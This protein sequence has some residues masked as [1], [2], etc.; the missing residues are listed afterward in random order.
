[1]KLTHQALALC[2]ALGLAAAGTAAPAVNPFVGATL[3]WTQTHQ[4]S[5]PSGFSSE[6]VAFDG[7]STTLWVAGVAGVDVLDARTGSSLGFIDT[8][9]FGSINSVAI[10]GGIAA[11]ALEAADRKQPGVVRLYDTTTRAP[12]PGVN[13]ITVGSLPDMLT[14]TPDGSRL[15]VAN[16]GTPNCCSPNDY[17]PE[18]TPRTAPRNYGYADAAEQTAKDPVGS[19]SII[20]MGSRSVIATPG[21]AGVPIVASNRGLNVRTNTGMDFEPEYIAVTE[22]G[23]APT[24]ACRRPTRS[25]CSTWIR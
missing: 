14:F 7:P 16:E 21:F 17:G 18:I 23:S 6:I 4:A 1:M 5:A 10:H 11:F 8:S 24:S 3:A 15:L 12:L 20:D 19:V 2:C 9:P 22:D 13:S 25:G